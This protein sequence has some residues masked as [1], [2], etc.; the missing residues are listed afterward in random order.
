MLNTYCFRSCEIDSSFPFSILPCTSYTPPSHLPSNKSDIMAKSG[1]SYLILQQWAYIVHFVTQ[2]QW[3]CWVLP[4][5]VCLAYEVETGEM[6]SQ[7]LT[8]CLTI[9]FQKELVRNQLVIGPWCDRDCSSLEKNPL[10]LHPPLEECVCWNTNGLGNWGH[11][12]LYHQSP[13][14]RVHAVTSV[15]HLLLSPPDP[16]LSNTLPVQLFLE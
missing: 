16:R 3:L 15:T 10:W 7:R 9:W 5:N 14:S 2:L 4:R 1:N 13:Q 12:P 11:P 6:P 8:N